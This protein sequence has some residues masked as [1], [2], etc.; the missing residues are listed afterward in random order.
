MNSYS[1][2]YKLEVIAQA[3][4]TSISEASRRFKIDRKRI[5][6]WI[7]N[8]QKLGASNKKRKRLL[9]GGRSVKLEDIDSQL[10][11]W[12]NNE[13]AGGLRVSRKRI[14]RKALELYDKEENKTESF[15]AS[16][17]WLFKFLRRNHFSLRRSTTIAQKMPE[18]VKQRVMNYILFVDGLKDNCSYRASAVGAADET[19]IWIDP[20][21]NTT[22]EKI[23]AKSVPVFSCGF[24]KTK[25]TVMLC[26]KSDGTKI[27]PFIV[28][29]GKK[30]PD[31][32]KNFRGAVIVLSSNGWM[33]EETTIQWL[34]KS[35]GAFAFGRRLL[36][37]DSFRSHKTPLVK[38]KLDALRTDVAMIPGGCTGILQAPDVSWNKP[39][40]A[41]YVEQYEKWL[42]EQGCKEENRTS[43]GNQRSPSKFLLCKWVVEAWKTVSSSII[44]KSFKIC[45]LTTKP[46]GSEDNEIH[47]VKLMNILDE[48][49]EERQNNACY[50][51]EED[52]FS[53]TDDDLSDD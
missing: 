46:N 53:S 34:D 5:R 21:Q 9:G 12:I 48:L 51:I 14:Q 19:A 26:A 18:D 13:R 2:E 4:R 43:A 29:K 52:V 15:C 25:V 1:I 22:V 27:A 10:V 11:E 39:F 47:A 32:L 44:I 16:D 38:K 49:Q 36:S 31:E 7:Q 30:L 33:N 41:A 17:G 35:W 28:L 6:E 23:G 20:I 50:N 45:A 37:W 24:H 8:E 40:K 42:Q 3:K